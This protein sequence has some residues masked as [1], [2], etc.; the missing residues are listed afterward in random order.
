[1]EARRTKERWERRAMET[2]KLKKPPLPRICSSRAPSEEKLMPTKTREKRDWH[3]NGAR[4][5]R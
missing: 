2:I 4:R 3:R 5:S 1:M